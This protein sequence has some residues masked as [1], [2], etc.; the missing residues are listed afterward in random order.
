MYDEVHNNTIALVKELLGLGDAFEVLLLGGGAT[1]HAATIAYNFLPKGQFAQYFKTGA[2]GTAAI[3]SAKKVG[4]VDIIYDGTEHNFTTLP[5]IEDLNIKKESAYLHLTSNETI[6]GIQWK[7]YPDTGDMPLIGD[8]CSDIAS[9]VFDASKFS[10][11]Y[12]SA[13]KNL[14]PA[15]VTIV[16]IR[17][18]FLETANTDLPD[19]L[20]YKLQVEK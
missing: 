19:Y 12:A 20:S 17:K 5:K 6:G 11:I 10:L 13:Q 18:D 16:I 14:G 9:R 1:L 15:G 8:M 3:K 2:W 7:E 4:D